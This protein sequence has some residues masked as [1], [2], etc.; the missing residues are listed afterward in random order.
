M[1]LRSTE[2]LRTRNHPLDPL[3]AAELE[4]AVRIL[5]REKYLGDGVRI[6][7]I[8]LMEPAKSL[9]EK[10]QPGSPFERK[11]LAVLLDRGKRA[12]YEAVV[13]LAGKSVDVGHRASQRRPAIDHAGRVQRVEQAVHRSPLFQAALQ[14]RG[15]T[16]ADL[17]MVEPW[18][19]GMY[20]TELPEE[21]RSAENAGA[22]LRAVRAERQRLRAA[23][24]QHGDRGGSLQNGSGPH[25]GIPHRAAAARAGQLGARV[26]SQRPHRI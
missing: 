10:H 4:E 7:S 9:V 20:G 12:S 24:R 18:S 5:A 26:H 19:A 1:R 21:Q 15:V 11:A 23:H 6:A 8:N 3:Y 22:V 17:V 13:D 16:D 14:K 25:R 2:R